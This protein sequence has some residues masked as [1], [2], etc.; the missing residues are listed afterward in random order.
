MPETATLKDPV[1]GILF[2]L[3]AN[4]LI[5]DM[6]A[7]VKH[8]TISGYSPME[9]L[10]F[11]GVIA[12]I[13]LSGWL[14]YRR[15]FAQVMIKDPLLGLY[16]LAAIGAAFLLFYAFGHGNLPQ[17]AAVIAAAPLVVALLSYFFLKEKLNAKQAG[18]IACGF[19]GILLVLKPRA[20][21]VPPDILVAILAGM[22]LFATSQVVVRK[23]SATRSVALACPFYFYLGIA[24][25]A[26]AL[27]PYHPVNAA[28]APYFLLCGLCDVFSLVC[29]YSALRIVQ[30]SVV[31][32][33]QY[34]SVLWSTAWGCL[35]WKEIP[36]AWSLAGG[37]V[38]VASGILFMKS[39]FHAA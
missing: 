34:S 32:P 28:D 25:I 33:F 22:A 30:A 12:S 23:L 10:F 27:M 37:V 24:V 8:L 13:I 1:S 3:T 31:A 9:V 5:S 11:D 26:G 16:V 29:L 35:F 7:L 14:A 17:M 2:A 6:N 21:S 18:L 19:L 20:A 15:S 36:D 39:S 4:F 38:I